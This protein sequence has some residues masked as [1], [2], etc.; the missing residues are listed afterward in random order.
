[1]W[2]VGEEGGRADETEVGEEG[3]GRREVEKERCEGT[4]EGV[5]AG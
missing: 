4:E 2:S 5:R 1:M 3:R